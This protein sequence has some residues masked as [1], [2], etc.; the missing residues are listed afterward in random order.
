M[1]CSSGTELWY[2]V[3]I[4]DGIMKT[5]QMIVIHLVKKLQVFQFVLHLQSEITILY[6]VESSR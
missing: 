1:S 3:T 5:T 6:L 2:P 4:N